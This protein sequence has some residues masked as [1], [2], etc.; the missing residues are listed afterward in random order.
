MMIVFLHTD[1]CVDFFV[2][3]KRKKKQYFKAA[4]CSFILDTKHGKQWEI[5]DV[6]HLRGL[7][8]YYTMI[9]KEY[10]ENIIK[11]QNEKWNVNVRD[12]FRMY[13]NGKM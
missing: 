4:L 7:L 13:L 8:S 2:Y 6:Q 1:Y 10:F 9:E 3:F 11:T 12:M 5:E